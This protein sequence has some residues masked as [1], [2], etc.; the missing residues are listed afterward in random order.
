MLGAEA[1]LRTLASSGVTTCFANPGTS[2]MHL[3][4][5][6]DAVP[7]MRPVLTLAEGV[8]SGAADGWA[9]VTGRPAATLLHL[10]PG[11]SNALSNLHNAKRAQSP[12]VNI[13]GDHASYHRASDAPLTSDIA[14]LAR[15]VSAWVGCA[16]GADDMSRA[17]GAAL[18]A[19]MGP[20][21]AIATLIVPADAAWGETTR[22]VE[23]VAPAAPRAP[24]AHRVEA[25]RRALASGA[26]AVLLIGGAAMRGSAVR[27]ASRA[28]NAAKARL[29]STTFTAV[30]ERGAGR[31]LVNRL[32]YFPEQVVEA[33]AGTRYLV[34]AGAS[35]PVA[36]FAYPGLPG[37]LVPDGC[38]VLTLAEPEEDV[39]AALGALAAALG[40]PD[41]GATMT[42][43]GP[44]PLPTGRLDPSSFA[45]A[46]G[47][48]LPEGAIVSDEAVTTRFPALAATVGSA[49]HDW[50]CL[51]GGSLGLGMPMALGAAL[52]APDR[53]VITLEA[54]GSAMYAPQALWSFAREGANVT[55]LVL[56]NRRYRILEVELERLQLTD[57]RRGRELLNLSAP[58]VDFVAL[59]RSMG[60]PGVRATTVEEV[61]VAMRRAFAEDG[62]SVVEVVLEG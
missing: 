17:A 2:E 9:R 16:A 20:P 61:V 23:S 44:P 39:A 52:A 7:S 54:D 34:L 10:G 15:T 32:P 55:T 35:V 1:L 22:P 51:T 27:D 46:L 41:N 45:Q 37:A 56:K 36:F 42:P 3:V 30:A 5:A 24:N 62:P 8:A 18:R 4:A 58:E 38:E 57:A 29:F 48:L 6:L 60:V 28:A 40:A 33:L 47:A 26:S 53:P 43:H 59:A 21:G 25:V 49:S 19:A 11:L 12:V 13:V 14:G 50:L 31:V